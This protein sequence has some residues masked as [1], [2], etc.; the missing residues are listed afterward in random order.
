MKPVRHIFYLFVSISLVYGCKKTDDVQ[1]P[2]Q[3]LSNSDMEQQTSLTSSRGNWLFGYYY[4]LT[5]NPNGYKASYTTE[6]AASGSH[7]LKISCSSIRNDTTFCYFEQDIFPTT[8]TPGKKLTLKAK[9]KTDNLVGQGVA[10]AMI[11]YKQIGNQNNIVFFP[12][13]EKTPITGTSDFK[14]YTVTLDSYPGNIDVIAIH[15][16]YLPKTT[17]T[18]FVDDVSLT[19]N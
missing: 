17:G 9:I 16:F 3:L 12:S 10:L 6:A 18:I 15:V 4:N 13:T 14:E 19:A 7:S 5:S 8:L 11:G 2:S 1:V